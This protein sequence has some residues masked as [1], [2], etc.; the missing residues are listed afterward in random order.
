MFLTSTVLLPAMDVITPYERE[1]EGVC[2]PEPADWSFLAEGS[3]VLRLSGLGCE[4]DPV[5]PE[6]C[7]CDPS[8][9]VV[10]YFTPWG[11]GTGSATV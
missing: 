8:A 11:T 3:G 7:L 9:T 10:S 5:Y 6:V 1:L 4:H 2:E